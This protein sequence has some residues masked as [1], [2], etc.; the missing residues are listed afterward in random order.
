LH[1]LI[2][3]YQNQPRFIALLPDASAVICAN[4]ESHALTRLEFGE[5]DSLRPAVEIAQVRSSV[6]VVWKALPE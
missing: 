5:A 3:I 2:S 1:L 6:C 4:E